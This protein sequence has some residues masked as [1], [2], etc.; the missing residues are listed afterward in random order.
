MKSAC[1]ARGVAGGEG[2]PARSPAVSLT[3]MVPTRT[4]TLGLGGDRSA[5]DARE[6]FSD[7][8]EFEFAEIAARDSAVPAG[9]A[10]IAGAASGTPCV[11]KTCYASV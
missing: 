2:R 5:D 6:Q 7:G 1:H 3:A 11:A 8:T 10:H 9:L 4:R